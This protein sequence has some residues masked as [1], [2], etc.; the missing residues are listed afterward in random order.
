MTKDLTVTTVITGER[1]D[2]L[3]SAVFG[4]A[5]EYLGWTGIKYL[6]GAGW[7]NPGRVRVTIYDPDD[8]ADVVE[9]TKVLAPADLWL[10][11]EETARR[12]YVDTC[13]GR[14]IRADEN[15]DFDACSADVVLQVAVLG[16][17]RF[18]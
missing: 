16:E 10:A 4:A 13:T 18:G 1:Q 7:C 5:P 3:W 8:P 11:A 15:F 17:A 12:G 9:G 2:A 14:P 6:D